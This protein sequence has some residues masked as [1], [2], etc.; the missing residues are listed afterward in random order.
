MST[1]GHLYA[2]ATLG[3]KNKQR[4]VISKSANI[5]ANYK[6]DE[7]GLLRG[8]KSYSRHHIGREE[9]TYGGQWWFNLLPS[10][11]AVISQCQQKEEG[12]TESVWTTAKRPDIY[13]TIKRQDK[14]SRL[15]TVTSLKNYKDRRLAIDKAT[16]GYWQHVPPRWLVGQIRRT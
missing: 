1:G 13:R 12:W 4:I 9:G 8:V 7:A 16:L 11:W 2:R 10:Q 5:K 15:I 3:R 14:Q 6:A